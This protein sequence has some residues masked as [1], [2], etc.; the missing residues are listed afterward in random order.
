MGSIA[1]PETYVGI[2]AFIW[3]FHSEWARNGEN[4]QL[5][6]IMF[7]IVKLLNSPFLPLSFLMVLRNQARKEGRRP[8]GVDHSR[9]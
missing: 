5:R 6:T 1:I 9:L 8:G 3:I 7:R 2:D 4:P